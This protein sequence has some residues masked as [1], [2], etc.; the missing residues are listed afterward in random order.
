MQVNLE[1][2][3]DVKT[4]LDEENPTVDTIAKAYLARD[5]IMNLDFNNLR[6]QY[7]RKLGY[8]NESIQQHLNHKVKEHL[9]SLVNT[10][11]KE[12]TSTANYNF[13][14][15]FNKV[16]TSEETVNYINSKNERYE[17]LSVIS[18]HLNFYQSLTKEEL[19]YLGW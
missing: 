3:P 10:F 15:E 9:Y 2:H 5:N 7:L 1:E 14:D 17:S 18:D 4:F 12:P 8:T 19:S 11:L 13:L 6:E 16:M